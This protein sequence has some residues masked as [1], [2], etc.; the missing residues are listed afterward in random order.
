MFRAPSQHRL[1]AASILCLLLC[2]RLS[3]ADTAAIPKP[4]GIYVLNENSNEQPAATAYSAGLTSSTAYQND[5]TGQ[6]IFVPIAKILPT[7]TTWGQFTW[8]WSYLDSL[9]QIATSHGK[10]ISIELETGYQASSSYLHSLPQNFAALAGANSAPLFDVWTV[11]GKMPRGI[12]AYILLPWVANVQEFW[13]AAAAALAA[14]LKQTGAYGSLTLVHVPGLSV[15][16]EELRLP[17][18]YPRP[19]AADTIPCPDGRPAYPACIDDADTSRWK[20][21]G[22]SDSAVIY[23][24]RTIAAAFAGAFPDKYLGL[25]LFNHA[26]VGIDFPN[27]AHDSAGYVASRIVKEV[28]A[29]APGRVQVQSDDLDGNYSLQEV[30]NYAGQNSDPVGWQSNKHGGTGAGCDG[31]GSGSCGLDGPTSL[32]FQLLRNGAQHGGT[33]LEVW[34]DDVVSFPLSFDAARGAGYHAVTGVDGA[35]PAAPSDYALEQNYPNPFN[36][37]TTIRY[38]LPRRSRVSLKVYSTLGQLVASPV[39]EEE[40]PGYHSIEFDGAGLASGVYF[41]R[42]QAGTFISTMK[43]ILLK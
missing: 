15:Y 10:K 27:L 24:F 41:Y 39:N 23:G 18:G 21:L 6:A 31:G 36:P 3:A 30:N 28:N 9:V 11:G 4:V 7:I 14:H 25:S 42:L 22:Y 12:S 5:I 38:A 13:S 16:D 34:S 17:G 43:S 26:T 20:S 32:Y 37:S 29:V 40:D 19:T 8:N 33:Y 35:S 1:V 2:Q